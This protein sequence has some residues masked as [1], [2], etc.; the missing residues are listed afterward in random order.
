MPSEFKNEPL[1]NF[2]DPQNAKAMAGALAQVESEL[3]REY[4]LLIGGSRKKTASR[5]NS[6][7]PSNP[8][9]VVGRAAKATKEDAEEAMQVASEAFESWKSVKPE[10]RA[11]YLFRA[12]A[13]MRERKHEFSAWMVY[14]VGKSWVEA[15]ADT[16][17]AIDFLEFYG[18]EMIRLADTQPLTK[19]PGEK[20]DLRY[21]PL[22]VGAVIPPWNFPVAIM[23]G[24]TSASFV[25]GNT[26][27]LKPSSD[28]PVVAAKFVEILEEI[29]LPPGVVNYLPGSGADVGDYVVQHPK[30]RFIAFTGSKE[31]GLRINQEA[32]VHREGQMWIKRAILEMGGKDSIIV[33]SGVDVDEAAKGVVASAFGFQ[34]QKCSACSRAIIV[35]SVYNATI[36]K[37]VAETKKLKQGA[38]YQSKD[39]SQ[40]PVVNESACEKILDYIEIGKTE[41][42]LVHGGMRA[43]GDGY[44]IHPTIFT[45]VP[46]DAKISQEEIFG[47]VLA[48]IKAD[49]FADALRIANNTEYG[50]TG[51]VYSKNRQHL[52]TAREVF[53]VGNLYLNRKCTG[54][55]VGVHPFGGF[56]MSGTDSKAGGR[57]Y[58]LLFTQAKAVSEKI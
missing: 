6:I 38:P 33:D 44:F 23:V 35:K 37:I 21:I 25:A 40:G 22:G 34:G 36:E 42:E 55:L 9:S 14:E 43:A 28:A 8:G 57:D 7:D 58:L 4:D 41:G 53:H 12:A 2:E 54:A 45:D 51:A 15:D 52:E 30:L 31:V 17:E 24:M 13:K 50:L 39:I 16:A 29:G 46:A 19:F 56:N 18:R 49:D 11:D 47:P 1:T 27:I 48:C 10:E 32:A 3:G 26:V 20:N 5:I